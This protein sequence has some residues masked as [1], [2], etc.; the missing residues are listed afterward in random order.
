M[1]ICIYGAGAMGSLLA[2]ALTRAGLDI[3]VVARGANLEAIRRDGVRVVKPGGES[4]VARPKVDADPATFGPQDLVIVATKQ[5]ALAAVAR[6]ITPL[7]GP[8]TLVAFAVNGVFWFYGEGFQPNGVE[9]DLGLLDPEGELRRRIGVGRALGV[10]CHAGGEVASPG[11]VETSR[12]TASLVIGAAAKDAAARTH[13]AIQVMSAAADLKIEET[14]NIRSQMWPKYASVIGI[15]AVSALTGGDVGQC[16]GDPQVRD[17]FI[18]LMQE[19]YSVAAAHGFADFKFDPDRLRT[20]TSRLGSHH[21]ASML[22]DLERRRPVEIDAQYV[23][24]QKLARQAGVSTPLL[25]VV[26][27]L[28]IARARNAGCYP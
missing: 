23:A 26:T 4:Y 21:K 10:V 3:A 25:D 1:R 9:L 13:I 22:Q 20:S 7:L 14:S 18:G 27:P 8:E 11:V 6:S 12:A 24:L 28:V 17:L 5:P 15:Q 16:L 2:G 19:A